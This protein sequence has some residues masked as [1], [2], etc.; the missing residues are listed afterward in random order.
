ME[1]ENV[2][3]CYLCVCVCLTMLVVCMSVCAQ[4]ERGVFMSP[5]PR[6]EFW[7]KLWRYGRGGFQV[8]GV[9]TRASC[10]PASRPIHCLLFE[11]EKRLSILYSISCVSL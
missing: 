4:C 9:L 1:S 5:R 10:H 7:R 6:G 8:L 2:Y 11:M 3:V